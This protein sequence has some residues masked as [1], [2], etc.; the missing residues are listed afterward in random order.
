MKQA[1]RAL[2]PGAVSRFLRP[3]SVAIVGMSTRPGSAGQVILRSLKLNE[4]SGDIHL[5]GRSA[6]QIDGR[7]MLKSASELPE[8]VDLAVFT[9]PAEAVRHAVMSCID[10]KVGS[11]LLFAAGFAEAGED[12]LQEEIA[13]AAREGGLAI[14]GPNCL[15]FT[16]N[17]DGLMLHMLNARRAKRLGA[18]AQP[19]LAIVGQSGGILG[20][21]QRATDARGLPLS[22][23]ISTGNESGLDLADF[24]D[25]LVDD[26]ATRVLVLY[27]E[28][29]RRP[30]QFLAALQR[31][32]AAGKPVI[33]MLP[34]RSRKA[35]QAALSHTGA[36]AGDHAMVRAILERAGAIVIETLDETMDV[37]ELLVRFPA[38]S[39]RDP[40]LLTGSGAFVAVSSDLAEDLGMEYAQLDPRTL[41]K[42]KEALP[43]YGTY[44]NPLDITAGA[45]AEA[46]P[47]AVRALLEDPN[48]GSLLIS[49][50]INTK[51]NVQGFN[52]GMAGSDKAKILVAL[53]DTSPLDPGVLEG[54]AESPA[55]FSRS[56]DRM[57]RALAHY[58][59]YGK[60]LARPS[61]APAA[62]PF[63]GLPPLREGV[64][65]EWLGKQV[66]AAAGVSVP[67]GALAHTPS[68]ALAIAGRVGFP[69]ALKAQAAGLAHKTEA[70]GVILGLAED[71]ALATAW[72]AIVQ[73]I[74]QRA[75]GIV[76][77]GCLVEKMAPKGIELMVG[78]RRDSAWGVV[79]LVGLGGIWVEVLGD[80]RV[81]AG[82]VP[83]EEIRDALLGLRSARLLQGFRGAPSADIGAVARAAATI[84]RLMQTEPRLK[85]IEI[86]P[87][88]ALPRGEG[89]LALDALLVVESASAASQNAGGHT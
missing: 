27:A 47:V 7:S 85:E 15:G 84:G 41:G 68:E 23:V 87:L 6:E 82:D 55:M 61:P 65:P 37:A 33:V 44:G 52:S 83:E 2:A 35:R 46:I 74:N 31:A 32:R 69:V 4:F 48:V 19:G 1:M 54:I 26:A 56:S 34:G 57:L 10:R 66:L 22:Y 78:A 20:H 29:V 60:L 59:R 13:V 64:L 8:G 11:A 50:P 9:L 51:E 21:F 58:A 49:Y 3:K 40:A 80:V 86:N 39:H 12:R 43:A 18:A 79:L 63:A 77:E 81:L 16:N 72:Q 89:V 45:K 25:F 28:Q 14:V 42:L 67:E 70:G 24:A 88:L 75:P 53:G 76:L 62:S 36:L 30:P 71:A 73:T 5:V 38:P 17:V